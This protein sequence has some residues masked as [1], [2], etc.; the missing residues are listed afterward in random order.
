MVRL[1]TPPSW[2]VNLVT[3]GIAR[4]RWIAESNRRLGQGGAGFW[5]AW[6]LLPFANYGLA[7]RMTAAL[8]QA[9]S[10]FTVSAFWCFW[11]T[12]WPFI[13]SAKRLKRGTQALNDAYSV[14]QQTATPSVV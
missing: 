10:S 11:L 1:E 4:A 2:I 9:G 6:F 13:G 14:R 8:Q 5:F 12:G 3:L 7:K